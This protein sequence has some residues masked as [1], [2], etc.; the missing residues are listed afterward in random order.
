MKSIDAKKIGEGL[1]DLMIDDHKALVA[2]GMIP[3]EIILGTM[4]LIKDRIALIYEEEWGFDFGSIRKAI[5][6]SF[7]NQIEHDISVGIY[8][9]AKECGRMVV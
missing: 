7:L 1:Y 3:H 2:F 9:R 8:S 5:K 6:K 4:E